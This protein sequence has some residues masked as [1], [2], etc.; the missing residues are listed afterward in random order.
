MN[1]ETKLRPQVATAGLD[2]RS[3]TGLVMPYGPP[4]GTSLGTVTAS[5][6]SVRL[7]PD[8]SRVKL[9]HGHS[10]DPGGYHTVGFATAASEDDAG[11]RMTFRV[12]KT[13]AG[14]TALLEASEGV[15][16]G[17]SVEL[18]GART[19]AQAHLTDGLITAVSLVPTPAWDD[20]RV[21][22][23]LA[24]TGSNDTNPAGDG[25]DDEDEEGDVPDQNGNR[26]AGDNA[27]T[28]KH[29]TDA[30]PSQNQAPAGDPGEHA[31]GAPA[32]STVTAA[33]ANRI[34]LQDRPMTLSQATQ[35]ITDYTF[36]RPL[37]AALEDITYSGAREAQAPK[38]LDELWSGQPFTREIVP[39]FTHDTL[40]A[41]RAIGWRWKTKP[42][43][44]P[45][46]GDKA[47]V[48]SNRVET[49][50]VDIKA[51]RLAGAHDI[52]RA[53]FDFGETKYL[54][55]YFDAMTQSYMMESDEAAATF[56]RGEAAKNVGDSQPDLITA[57]AKAQ[58]MIKRAVRTNATTFLVHPDDM[59]QLLTIT[60]LDIPEYLSLVGVTPDKFTQSE[61]AKKGSVIA[62]AKPALTFFELSGSPIRVQA[63]HIAQGGR[64][65]GLFGYWAAICNDPRGVV[66]VPFATAPT[67]PIGGE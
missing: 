10:T 54:S 3:I 13:P 1:L 40:T 25:E 5:K 51:E 56:A 64:D 39:T 61:Q 41:M 11:L 45:Y 52:D 53:F 65:A 32:A 55:G 57:A 44:A 27:A 28:E 48:P 42:K 34:T 21:T 7:P 59:F 66:E 9:F 26:N 62:Y 43:V 20:A 8:L 19:N 67:G 37:T 12:A 22:A 31:G 46:A 16:D 29:G 35:A 38:W 36:R 49:E 14:D 50:A 24:D 6:G 15:R 2:E 30:A 33:Q 47:D 4:G 18:H 60:K 17:L 63:E 58:Q 23:E